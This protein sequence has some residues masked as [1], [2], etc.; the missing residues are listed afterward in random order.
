MTA[1]APVIYPLAGRRVWVA[2]HR[3]MVGSALRRRLVERGCRLVEVGREALDLRRQ[4]DVEAWLAANRPDTVFVAAAT[5]GGIHA[6]DTRPAEFIYDNLAIVANV[7]EAA[8]KVAVEKLM[9]LGSSCM[10][11]RLAAQPITEDALMTGPLEPTNEWYATA[12][13]AGVRLCQAYRRQY[14][15]DFITVTPTNLYG[16]GDDFDPETSH[17]VA[18]LI[19]RLY[20][21]RTKGD[22]AVTLWGTGTP[23]REFLFVDDAAEALVFLME[24][25]SSEE[26]INVGCGETVSIHRLATLVAEAV[27]YGGDFRYDTDRPDGMPRK[28][29]DSRRISALGWRPRVDL[30]EGLRRTV[31]WYLAERPVRAAARAA[32]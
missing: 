7:V 29:L 3:G 25:Y 9:V 10:Y 20:E 5:V 11:P 26:N 32:G 24:R 21:A 12:K 22:P 19:R 15:C 6:N 23:H 2:G 31:A 18:A 17:V 16:P 28:Q 13:I 4:A 14:G 1:P 27:G 30:R 8:R